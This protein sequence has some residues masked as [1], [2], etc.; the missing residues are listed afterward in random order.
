MGHTAGP[1]CERGTIHGK[2][3]E[4]AYWT[5]CVA[6]MM[7]YGVMGLLGSLPYPLLF[8]SLKGVLSNNRYSPPA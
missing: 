6:Q 8:F 2:G 7:L 5:V 4:E 1:H 3:K